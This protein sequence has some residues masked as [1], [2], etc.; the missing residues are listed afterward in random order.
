MDASAG[1][2][3]ITNQ[4]IVT[5]ALGYSNVD[6]IQI[7]HTTGDLSAGELSKAVRITIDET[8]VTGGATVEIDGIKLNR[9][10]GDSTATTTA[11]NVG[12]DFSTALRVKS[13]PAINPGYGYTFTAAFA[14]TDRVNSGGGGDNSFINPAVNTQMF[15]A[16]NTGILIGSDNIFSVIEY[17]QQVAGSGTINPVWQYSTGSGTWATLIVSDT[18]TNMRFSGKISFTSP[19]GWAKSDRCNGTTGTITNAYYVRITR[20]AAALATPPTEQYF[21]IYAGSIAT[22]MLIRGDG[23]IQPAIMADTTAPN[24][25]IYYST[26]AS[27]LVF[28]DSGGVVRNLY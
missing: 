13:F 25:S 11:I 1:A 4:R 3:G 10:K 7:K 28:K 27:K 22:D 14:V 16:N 9:I 12:T 15:T 6:S 23:T 2:N 5:D 20:T 26:D 8:A 21:K 18:T 19:V 24:V 17:I